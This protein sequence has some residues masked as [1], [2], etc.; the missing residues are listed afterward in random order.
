MLVS[1][2]GSVFAAG[3]LAGPDVPLWVISGHSVMFDASRKQTSFRRGLD[4]H[5]SPELK[6]GGGK[7]RSGMLG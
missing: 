4:I 2:P 7:R 1:K 5:F 6:H 3:M